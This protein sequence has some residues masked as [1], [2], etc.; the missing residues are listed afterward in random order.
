MHRYIYRERPT[1]RKHTDHTDSLQWYLPLRKLRNSGKIA[2]QKI[3]ES[4]PCQEQWLTVYL[5]SVLFI[6]SVHK[7]LSFR[8]YLV[9]EWLIN[10]I[11]YYIKRQSINLPDPFI[12]NLMQALTKPNHSVCVWDQDAFSGFFWM[13]WSI[14]PT[15]LHGNKTVNT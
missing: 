5:T 9:G 14:P 13:S 15:G 10:W 6:L 8:I 12:G 4:Y 7:W 2:V 1:T 3:T 11:Y